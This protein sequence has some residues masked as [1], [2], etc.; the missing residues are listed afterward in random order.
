MTDTSLVQQKL[1]VSETDAWNQQ[2]E[3]AL[4]TW[5]GQHGIDV[6]GNP[7]P[8]SLAAMTVYDPVAGAPRSFHESLATG[9]EPGTFGRDYATVMNQIPRW[10]WLAL[11]VSFVGLAYLSWWRRG[12]G[13][14]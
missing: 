4:A 10:A 11:G 12:R 3:A 6:S 13:Q 7:D 2:T 1:G 14:E 5:Q 9:K 8:I